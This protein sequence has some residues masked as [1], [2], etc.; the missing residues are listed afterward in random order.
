MKKLLLG[1]P[2]VLLLASGCDNRKE[3]VE[4]LNRTSDSLMAITQSRDSVIDDFLAT[5]NEIEQNL[6]S[7]AQRQT[8]IEGTMDRQGE[9][10]GN[11]KDRINEDIA[12]INQL[13]QENRGKVE[14]LTKKLKR[15]NNRIA[16][17]QKSIAMLNDQLSRKETELTDL[18][19]RLEGLNMQVAQLQTSVDTLTTLSNTQAG[20]ISEQTMALHTAYYVVG[21]AKDLENKKI[22]DQ[23]GGLLGVGKTTKVKSDFNK[24]DFT[25]IDYTQTQVIPV[26]SKDVK[27]ATSH[28]VESYT[29]EKDGNGKVT[30]L[31]INEPEKF[32]SISKYL[33]V[34]KG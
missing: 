21:N 34:I 22:V 25:M 2:A 3:E 15:S 19:T 30:S 33:V 10:R 16:Q 12:A 14:E 1:I 27:I 8:K 9:T 7:I 31:K 4:R 24:Q 28:P 17:F 5:F 11:M 23:T 20:T 13:M 32:W 6:D 18:N 29:L 26:E